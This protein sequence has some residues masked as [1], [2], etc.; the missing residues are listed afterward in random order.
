M[1]RFNAAKSILV[2]NSNTLCRRFVAA[3]LFGLFDT[4][5]GN[6]VKDLSGMPKIE[7]HSP[8]RLLAKK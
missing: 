8:G 2:K 7:S 3:S 6:I 1:S 5:G 4:A